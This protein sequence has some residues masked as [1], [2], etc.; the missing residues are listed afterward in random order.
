MIEKTFKER[1]T[2]LEKK[3]QKL[4]DKLKD[5]G[6]RVNESL[7]MDDFRDYE[8][9][10]IQSYKTKK[11]TEVNLAGKI[12]KIG[13]IVLIGISSKIILPE[14]GVF[15]I[16]YEIA[17]AK[18]NKI[19]MVIPL[20]DSCC[21][22]S[23]KGHKSFVEIP[24]GLIVLNPYCGGR[25]W[26]N[27]EFRTHYY[28]EEETNARMFSR[29]NQMFQAETTEEVFEILKKWNTFDGEVAKDYYKILEAYRNF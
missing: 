18:E 3:V 1:Y 13:D 20:P 7:I 4:K 22:N 24:D 19:R 14:Y 2:D 11:E 15:N 23:G 6:A 21:Y 26:D 27:G 16:N 17:F 5:T 8:A 9:K 25:S 12:K 28:S 29:R 10:K